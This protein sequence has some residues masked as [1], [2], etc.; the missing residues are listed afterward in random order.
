M[1]PG[2]TMRALVTLA[3]IVQTVGVDLIAMS[4]VHRPL[5]SL[6]SST[7]VT[8]EGLRF[9]AA[10][11]DAGR[12]AGSPARPLPV[13][14]WN[15]MAK[16]LKLEA[17]AFIRLV[18]KL[19]RCVQRSVATAGAL[20]DAFYDDGSATGGAPSFA[21][22][23]ALQHFLADCGKGVGG[24]ARDCV[25]RMLRSQHPRLRAHV[26]TDAELVPALCRSLGDAFVAV[27]TGADA[28]SAD[29]ARF[30]CL[31]QFTDEVASSDV[32]AASTWLRAVLEGG[33]PDV[34]ASGTSSVAAAVLRHAGDAVF[35]RVRSTL[36]EGSEEQLT[37]ATA[38][39]ASTIKQ[40][41][42]WGV[43]SSVLLVPFMVALVGRL[44]PAEGDAEAV[45][46]DAAV[47]DALLERVCG[48][49][50]ASGGCVWGG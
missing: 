48:L 9:D 50:V 7:Y 32:A 5:H 21:L 18:S 30:R 6:M 42:Q 13:L 20:F 37:R 8:P 46:D 14:Q 38:T 31:L 45:A 47:C 11:S 39:T 24:A 43:E 49:Y 17:A 25:L 26:C 44:L 35:P 4:S 27:A 40:L 2:L 19:W 15:K 28:S 33:V 1:L 10:S 36:L 34:D 16:R 23:E 29:L 22:L 3:G 41:G 12:K